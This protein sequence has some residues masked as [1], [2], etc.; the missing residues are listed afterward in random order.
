MEVAYIFK[1][2]VKSPKM[3]GYVRKM[4]RLT[5]SGQTA[6]LTAA[7][8]STLFVEGEGETLADAI[9]GLRRGDVLAVVWAHVL[10]PPRKSYRDKPRDAL[11]TAIRAIEKRGA[12]IFEVETGRSTSIQAERDGIIRD[13]IEHLTSA[14]RA[15]A[16]RKNGRKSKGRP[17]DEV[18][19]DEIERARVAWFD[20]RHETNEAA[21]LAGPAG[22]SDYRY[23]KHFGPSGR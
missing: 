8:C 18:E 7:G 16:G 17:V 15:A 2:V 10:T 22:W 21:R 9:S 19:P 3:R 14:G 11:W 4:P 20:L 13:A 23:R 5:E 6:R 1:M 12:T